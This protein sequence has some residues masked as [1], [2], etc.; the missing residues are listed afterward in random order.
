[1]TRPCGGESRAIDCEGRP[2]TELRIPQP[3][4]WRIPHK[5]LRVKPYRIHLLEALTHDHNARRLQFCTEMQEHLEEEEVGF[6]KKLI[7]SDEATFRLHGKANR[8]NARIWRT[9]N[10]HDA[11]EH[12]R[13]S[14]EL[15]VFFRQQGVQSI[16]L[17]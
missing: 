15:K 7:F 14:P 8:R 4:L 13:D 11:T 16:F 3:I 12:M 6:A 2:L 5:R 1:M 17:R 9:E 10:P